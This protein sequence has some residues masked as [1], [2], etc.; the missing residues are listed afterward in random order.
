MTYN[1][2]LDRWLS[3]DPGNYAKFENDH[4]DFLREA[5]KA[6]GVEPVKKVKKGMSIELDS[7]LLRYHP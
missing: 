2:W 7:G 3:A 4:P 6:M 1:E 5:R